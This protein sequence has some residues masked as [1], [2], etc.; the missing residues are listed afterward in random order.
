MFI[1]NKDY[2]IGLKYVATYTGATKTHYIFRGEFTEFSISKANTLSIRQVF[3]Y[4]KL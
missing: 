1:E 2:L 4:I 3:R